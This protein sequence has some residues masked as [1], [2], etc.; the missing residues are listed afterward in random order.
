MGGHGEEGCCGTHSGGCT[1][2]AT[3]GDTGLLLIFGRANLFGAETQGIRVP[4]RRALW[5]TGKEADPPKIRQAGVH[6]TWSCILW[7]D[8]KGFP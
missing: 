6:N 4:H 5:K 1:S 2:V 3:V 7:S 8:L